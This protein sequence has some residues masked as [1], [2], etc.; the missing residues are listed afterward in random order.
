MA[1]NIRESHV[2]HMDNGYCGDMIVEKS[3][4]KHGNFVYLKVTMLGYD[5]N[6]EL[7]YASEKEEAFEQL[8]E[9][10]SKLQAIRQDLDVTHKE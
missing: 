2:V 4:T 3:V 7:I 1:K 6:Q 10:I 9:L 8:D 5:H